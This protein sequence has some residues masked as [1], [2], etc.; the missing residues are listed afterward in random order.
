MEQALLSLPEH[1]HNILVWV[2]FVLLNLVFFVVFGK[3]L[4]LSII[5]WPLYYMSFY[6][7]LITHLVSSAFSYASL[8]SRCAVCLTPNTTLLSRNE[9]AHS[10]RQVCGI[11]NLLHDTFVLFL[12]NEKWQVILQILQ[13]ADKYCRMPTN[14]AA[15][16]QTTATCRQIMQHVDKLLPH[17][18]KIM[19]HANKLLQ[20]ADKILHHADKLVEMYLLYQELPSHIICVT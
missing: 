10:L 2:R 11:F 14:N 12:T 1:H 8:T 4:F 20:H 3:L 18:D 13:H 5:F 9:V 19:Q 16:R 7:I 6:C 15:C 17:A